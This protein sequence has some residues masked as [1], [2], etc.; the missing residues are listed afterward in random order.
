MEKHQI[1]TRQMLVLLFAGMLS[2]TIRALPRRSMWYGGTGGWLSALLAMVPVL[3]VTGAILACLRRMPKGSGLG[4]LLELSFGQVGGRVLAGCYAAW[5]M[6]AT[7]VFLR[8]YS[9]RFLSTTYANSSI[10]LFLTAMLLM[11]LWTSR[12]SLGAFARMGEIFFLILIATLFLVIGM[13]VGQVK[14]EHVFP[15]WLEDVP[16][17][18]Y[19]TLPAMS[20]LSYGVLIF[21]LGGQ[22]K[23]L[24]EHRGMV[25]RWTM[26]FGLLLTVMQFVTVGL[27]GAPMVARMQVPFF[28]LTKEIDVFGATERLESIIIAL[29]VI[30]DVILVGLMVRTACTALQSAFRLASGQKVAAPLVIAMLPASILISSSQFTLERFC[31]TVLA[32]GNMIL[33]YLL[34]LLACALAKIRKRL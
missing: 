24:P 11:T 4:E 25:L 15:L 28:M 34:P 29:W 13:T 17:I 10:Y 27:F 5:T 22:T 23:D 31:V 8:V 21:F 18:L 9:E 7:A 19:S 12:G 20:V 16:D 26:G 3:L 2:P 1:S 30:T 6:L 14:L 33:C 32:W